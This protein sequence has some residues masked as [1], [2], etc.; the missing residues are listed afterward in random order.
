MIK[1]FIR[2]A[3]A[4]ASIGAL[5]LMP[6]GAA[7]AA[8]TTEIVQKGSVTIGVLTGI[9]PYTTVDSSGNPDGFLVDIARDIAKDLNV[10]LDIVPVNNS[11]RAA[12]LQ[13]GRVDLRFA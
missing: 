9:P 4:A 12:A 13:S 2:H 1:G 3:L 11:S 5:A 10:K 7:Q 8:T 6:F